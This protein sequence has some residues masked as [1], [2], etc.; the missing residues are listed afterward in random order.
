MMS[1]QLSSHPLMVTK[2]GSHVRCNDASISTS[3]CLHRPGSHVRFLVLTLV[4][5]RRTCEPALKADL[6]G[7][8]LSHATSFTT[9]LQY[10]K[11]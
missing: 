3:L 1:S 9:R 2:A 4:S 10:E 6:Q 5:L 7:V 11:S 8:I